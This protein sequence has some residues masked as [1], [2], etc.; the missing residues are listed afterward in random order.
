MSATLAYNDTLNFRPANGAVF[1][2]PSIHPEMVLEVA[3][4]VDPIDTGAV[5]ADAFLEHMAD[6]HA[7][8]PSFFNRY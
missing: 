2:L 4:A 5:P 1:A 7:K 3:A 6:S 8:A